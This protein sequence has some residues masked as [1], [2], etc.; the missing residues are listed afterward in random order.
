[1]IS[2]F[3]TKTYIGISGDKSKFAPCDTFLTP[4][5]LEFCNKTGLPEVNMAV[6]YDQTKITKNKAN[7]LAQQHN[8]SRVPIYIAGTVRN[9]NYSNN[10]YNDIF[11]SRDTNPLDI[12]PYIRMINKKV[13]YSIWGICQASIGSSIIDFISIHAWGVNFESIDAIDSQLILKDAKFPLSIR[14]H[15][16]FY[17][18]SKKMWMSIIQA[19]IDSQSN[20][21]DKMKSLVILTPAI[22][23]GAYLKYLVDIYDTEFPDLAIDRKNLGD[24]YWD[25]PDSGLNSDELRYLD[26]LHRKT[27]NYQ[28]MK[29]I[30]K[31]LNRVVSLMR[32]DFNNYKIKIRVCLQ[33]KERNTCIAFED[34][35]DDSLCPLLTR[36]FMD[37]NK[38]NPL[39][40]LFK[41]LDCWDISRNRETLLNDVNLAVVNAWDTFSWIGNGGS[42][43]KSVDGFYVAGWL[44]GKTFI[45][46]SYLLNSS[47]TNNFII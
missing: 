37:K 26:N 4:E 5:T 16:K 12:M 8:I 45:N 21:P 25:N 41:P 17:E 11:K 6:V 31:A 9:V 20:N 40:N 24:R 23:C 18:I 42:R 13:T 32:D 1:M 44:T 19:G 28:Y 36:A 29:L 30:F 14:A 10:T 39:V 2:S 46:N 22:G 47:Y 27:Y 38:R 3:L 34:M 35:L 15:K 7:T 43:D 33:T